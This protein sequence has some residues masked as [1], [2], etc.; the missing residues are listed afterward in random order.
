M[1]RSGPLLPSLPSTHQDPGWPSPGWGRRGQGA[2]LSCALLWAGVSKA[3]GPP[4]LNL[5]GRSSMGCQ[6]FS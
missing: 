1:A 3:L 2:D 5:S 4:S 6:P